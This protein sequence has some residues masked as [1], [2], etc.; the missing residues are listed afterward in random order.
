MLAGWIARHPLRALGL[1]LLAG[2]VALPFALRVHIVADLSSM[3]PSGEAA[4]DDYR[5]FLETF[6]G[7]ESLF[8]GV[9]ALPGEAVDGEDLAAA[10]EVLA[11]RLSA[12]TAVRSARAGILPESESFFL[13]E[14]LPR[15]I[16]FTDPEDD[17]AVR[18]RL[19]PEAIRERVRLLHEELLGPMGGVA[20]TLARRDPL[21]LAPWMAGLRDA[22]AGMDA[23][24][25]SFLSPE[26][27]MALVVAAPASSELDVASGR[28]VQEALDEASAATRLETGLPIEF[29]AV[30]GP[31]YAVQDEAALRADLIDTGTASLLLVLVILILASG[32]LQ[33]PVAALAAVGLGAVW[34]LGILGELRGSVTAVGVGFAAVLIGL[35][36][37]YVVHGGGEFRS[38]L[39]AGDPRER[40]LCRTFRLTG[41]GILASAL[42]TFAGFGCL[43]FARFRPLRELG[44]TVAIGIGAILVA[45]VLAGSSL[46][47]LMSRTGERSW[48]LG[49]AAGRLLARIARLCRAHPVPVLAL[50][51]GM[52]VLAGWGLARARLDPDPR[53]LRPESHPALA[54]E[55]ALSRAFS[56][57]FET[58]TLMVP[59]RDLGEALD[60]AAA[61]RARLRDLL[62]EEASIQS[63]SDW[64]LLGA[65]LRE[66]VAAVQALPL[67]EAVRAL[68]RELD[69]D[70]FRVEPFEP[71]LRSLEALARGEVPP[72]PPRSSWPDWLRESIRE[73]EDGAVVAIRLR[74]PEE[75]WPVGPPGP[76]LEDL[77]GIAPGMALAS[78][79]RVGAA[80]RRVALGDLSR[81][82]GIA[83]AIVG[84]AVLLGFRG[85]PIPA[86]LAV[87]PVLLGSLWTFGIWGTLDVP[88]DLFCLA[89][90]PVMLGIGVDDGLHV[91]HR[92]RAS[93]SGGIVSSVEGA[94]AAMVVT[95]LTTAAGFGSLYLSHVPGLRNGGTMI[96]VGV[97]LTLL[98]TVSVVP[99]LAGLG[100]R[101]RRG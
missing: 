80:L 32:G 97:L 46:L 84:V 37:D 57:Q 47:V 7:A 23:L 15:A 48:S 77:A 73:R 66:R 82:G 41:P 99:A 1:G 94:G 5:E 11:D 27:D 26:R 35:G 24:T 58:S 86:L 90:L 65:R 85:R 92:T 21:G 56:L 49:P 68:R 62:E 55:A 51:A 70:G 83:A 25:G 96:A 78:A 31:L 101:R 8:V 17:A 100:E 14:V 30:G 98:V 93:P 74:L 89:V 13:D 61:L 33:V 39:A 45:T 44:L 95:T 64:L 40:A 69:A 22:P 42:T 19:E 53:R 12:H 91:L 6:G 9:R 63:P 20:G 50:A 16:L 2:L 60:R 87:L 71:A 52:S 29:L 81:L 76:V 88:L 75:R 28:R 59:G 4:F 67:A 72:S 38:R 3:L 43:A 54:A 10:A 36:V 34:T 79:G 18:R